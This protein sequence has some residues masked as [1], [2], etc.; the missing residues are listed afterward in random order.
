MIEGIPVLY[1]CDRRACEECHEPCRHT[2]D[3]HH[4]KNFEVAEDGSMWER[5]QPVLIFKTNLLLKAEDMNRIREGLLTQVG[6]GLV[7]CGPAISIESAD[8]HVIYD[9]TVT[10]RKEE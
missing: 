6:Q 5:P 9:V 10:K 1:L 3:I 7:L 8:G 2:P 4:A